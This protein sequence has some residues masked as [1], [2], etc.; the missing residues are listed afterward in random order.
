AGAG[1]AR[2]HQV[3]QLAVLE[4]LGGGRALGVEHLAAKGKNRLTRSVAS[5]F[6]GSAGGVALDDEQL[7]LGAVG[8]G[9]VGQL[10]GQRQPVLGGRL[11]GHLLLRGAAR[12][13]GAGGQNDPPDDGLGHAAVVIEPVLESGADEPVDG[14]GQLRV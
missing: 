7:A 10:A 1:A 13:A 3:G 11:A 14:G 5:L 4:H 9:A 2:R 12:L 6:G 8:G